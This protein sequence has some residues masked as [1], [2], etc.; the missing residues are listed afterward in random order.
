M[1][2][3]NPSLK[4]AIRALKDRSKVISREL[5]HL[6]QDVHIVSGLIDLK[7]SHNSIFT[8]IN[9]KNNHDWL[10]YYKHLPMGIDELLVSYSDLKYRYLNLVK[11]QKNIGR[12]ILSLRGSK[13]SC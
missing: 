13:W 6:S 12:C 4:L 11:E 9:L 8:K 7:S 1:G 2:V 10:V 3:E 5:R